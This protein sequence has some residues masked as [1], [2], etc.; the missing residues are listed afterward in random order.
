MLAGSDAAPAGRRRTL[1]LH[2]GGAGVPPGGTTTP[3]EELADGGP[4]GLPEARRCGCPKGA[5][6][7]SRRRDET[8]RR[9]RGPAPYGRRDGAPRGATCWQRHVTKTE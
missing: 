4:C 6:P 9:K 8:E 2:S 5:V 3:R 1:L 7:V